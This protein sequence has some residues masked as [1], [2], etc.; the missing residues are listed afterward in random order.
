MAL[1]NWFRS[2]FILVF[3][4]ISL[5]LVSLGVIFLALCCR[6]S[7]PNVRLLSRC[8]G[9]ILCRVSGVTVSV[10][11]RGNLQRGQTYIFAANHQSQF[12]IPILEGYMLDDFCWMAKK[13]LFKIPLFGHAMRSVGFIPV[14]RKHGRKAMQSLIEAAKRIAA[15]ASVIIFPEGTRSADGQLQPFKSGAMVLAIK[16]G[17]SLVPV[18]I[19]G[20]YKI[21][22][23]GKLMVRAG[24]VSV[25]IGKPIEIGE[26]GP[27]QKQELAERLRS[28]VSALM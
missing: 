4:P 12:D 21:L 16:A 1:L 18:A 28:E 2:S 6:L 10:E 9:K 3:A 22:P 20:S 7:M 15:G 23:K 25:K 5:F 8:W 26:F 17:V 14:D 13:E 27:R 11:G 24:K 19:N